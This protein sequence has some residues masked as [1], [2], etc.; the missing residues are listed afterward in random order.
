MWRLRTTTSRNPRVSERTDKEWLRDISGRSPRA[1][2]DLRS[3]LVSVL[4]NTLRPR[5]P[6]QSKAMAQDLAQDALLSIL[7]KLA[8]FR[9]E[10]RFTTWCAKVAVRHALTELRRSRWQDVPL[11]PTHL[12][13]MAAEETAQDVL[14]SQ[15]E[16]ARI[17][18]D[19]IH[20]VLSERQRTALIAVMQDDMPLGEVARRL[21]T[22]RN[23][24][25]KML[26]DARQKLRKALLDQGLDLTDF[27][28]SFS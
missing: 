6:A 13:A 10:A 1:L 4:E 3:L 28:A 21:G 14:L 16:N 12:S 24:L 15:S 23:A 27:A 11:Q 9:G 5:V 19:A 22:N 20:S 17:L 7:E 2:E 8:M 26:H 18:R 25:Y